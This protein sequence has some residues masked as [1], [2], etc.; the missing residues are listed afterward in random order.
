M[1]GKAGQDSLVLRA[2]TPDKHQEGRQADEQKAQQRAPAA[3]KAVQQQAQR[4]QPGMQRAPHALDVLQ[5]CRRQR[6]DLQAPHQHRPRQ[7]D[8]EHRAHQGFVLH[9][10]GKIG[11]HPAPQQCQNGRQQRQKQCGGK[12]PHTEARSLPRSQ[13]RIHQISRACGQHPQPAEHKIFQVQR[14][15]LA[16]HHGKGRHRQRQHDIA[17]LAAEHKTAGCE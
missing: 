8:A 5:Q 17:V 16:Q 3:H 12:Q 13:P 10:A 14:Q 4:Q 6:I 1:A 2:H 7:H 15:D 9:T 11:D